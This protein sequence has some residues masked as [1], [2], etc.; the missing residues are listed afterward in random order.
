[1]DKQTMLDYW[2]L[3]GIERLDEDHRTLQAME[4]TPDVRWLVSVAEEAK[5]AHHAWRA[6]CRPDLVAQADE[7]PGEWD[8]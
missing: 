6:R 4:P 5:R 3:M 1:M 8:T 2:T 7:R